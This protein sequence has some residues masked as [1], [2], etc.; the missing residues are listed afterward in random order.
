MQNV[1]TSL[2]NSRIKRVVKLRQRRNRDAARKTIV[3]GW[4]ELSLAIENGFILSEL[5]VCPELLSQENTAVLHTQL[6]SLPMPPQIFEVSRPIFA[7]M[8]YRESSDGLIGVVSYW[9]AR[10]EELPLEKR[11]FFAAIEN[12]EKPGN[13]GAILRTTDAVGV[14]GVIVCH[15]EKNKPVDLFNPNVIRASLGAIFTQRVAKTDTETFIQWAKKHQ[16]TIVAATP[17]AE[18]LYTAV[19]YTQAVSIVTGS[20]AFGLSEQLMNAAG[21]TAVIPMQGQTNSLN[22]SVSTAIMLFEARRQRESIMK[23]PNKSTKR[24]KTQ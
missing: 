9:S 19:D 13:L 7:K 21:E 14:D 18:N 4:R 16:I 12:V 2:Q 23:N 11:P 10:I 15:S 8:A 24:D 6:N 17:E 22:L 5:F 20:E 3:E 1:I